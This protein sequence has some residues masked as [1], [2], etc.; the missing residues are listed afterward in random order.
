[1]Q[2]LILNLEK[3]KSE[4]EYHHSVHKRTKPRLKMVG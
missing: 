1:M 3:I 2:W 4:T